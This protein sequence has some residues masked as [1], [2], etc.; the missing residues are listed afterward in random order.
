[1]LGDLTKDRVP[2]ILNRADANP[3]IRLFADGHLDEFVEERITPW[4][5]LYREV[6][7]PCSASALIARVASALHQHESTA[8]LALTP[9]GS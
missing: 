4:K 1:V 7:H 9:T 8:N 3:V 2:E 6:R 5:H